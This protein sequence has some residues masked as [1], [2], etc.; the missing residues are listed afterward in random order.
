MRVGMEDRPKIDLE[1]GKHAKGRRRPRIALGVNSGRSRWIKSDKGVAK[2]DGKAKGERSK[3][4]MQ[5]R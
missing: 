4:G 3:R 5:V 2:K 1:L